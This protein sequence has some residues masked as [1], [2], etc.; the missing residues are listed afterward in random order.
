[1]SET[2]LD[3]LIE[4][5]ELALAFNK[6]A[7]A[8]PI[9]LL[10]PDGNAQ[11]QS[12]IPRIAQRRPV[13]TY[14]SYDPAKL[15][16]PAYWIRCALAGTVEG[17]P[18]GQTPVIYLPGIARSV[19]RTVASVP[20]DIG[21]IAELQFRA[22]WFSH[23]GDHDW[24][25]RSFLSNPAGLGLSVADSKDAGEAMLL[26]LDHLL[27]LPID[28]VS[29]QVLDADFF[30]DLVNP[31]PVRT[32]LGWLDD[33]T[34]YRP[35]L[36]EAQWSAFVQQCR[37]DFGFDPLRDGEIAAAKKLVYR[38]GGWEHVWR[39]FRETPERYPGIPLQL[40][41]AKPMELFVE[42]HEAWPQDN[43]SAEQQL[44]DAL[45]MLP[46]L[47]TEEAR[48]KVAELEAQHAWRRATVWADLDRA[49][50]AF[51]VEQLAL[52]A[53]KSAKPM[54]GTDLD[55]LVAAYADSGWRTDDVVLGAL[56]VSEDP[57]N[58]TA[59]AGAVQVLYRP[60]L[61]AG[62]TTLQKVVGPMANAGT[63]RSDH[64]VDPNPGTVV[65]FVDGLRLDV[66][67]RLRE[68]LVGAGADVELSTVLSALPTVT[69]TAK[70]A[71]VP[72]APGAL[73]TGPDLHP[74]NA[75]TGTR[76]GTPVLRSL[77]ADNN[78]AVL[79][80]AELG[81]PSVGAWTEA[82]DIDRH[83]HA[84]GAA[85]VDSLEEDLGRIARR[86]QELLDA[87]WLRVE[88]VTDHGW[89]LLPGGMEKVDLPVA[90][91]EVKKGRCARL[92]EGSSVE[93]PTVPWHWDPNVRIAVAPG[94]S[95]FE[96]GKEYEHGGVS[97]QECIV[98]RMVVTA[99]VRA[100][101]GTRPEITEVKWLGLLCRIEL[102]GVAEGVHV[103]LRALPADATTS[104]AEE[105]R[106]STRDGR[107]SL[108]VPDEEHE[109][110][111]AYIVLIAPDGAILAQ[112][113]VSVG[114]NR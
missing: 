78:I 113:P 24:T 40:Q 10:W 80:G 47:T 19:M 104:I 76:A 59:V 3:R 53:E 56:A 92:K 83:G 87:G 79:D 57:K 31:D 85:M 93:V 13:L 72:V 11:W 49:P 61:D 34:G 99:G 98:P 51:A 38:E 6:N 63:Y 86:V 17:V 29:R 84:E 37:D 69:Q 96:A 109:G 112:R 15:Q 60:W 110:E 77:M 36:T 14:G 70:A 50:L 58:R 21:P 90:A 108:L 27:D 41:K 28:Q 45:E 9:A 4:R 55:H 68:R 33:P 111:P 48:H 46:K 43:E 8:A 101:A 39:R 66:A 95:C 102:S 73:T 18:T 22:Q 42:P 91:T 35:R 107:V 16:G 44:R 52:L 65:M 62:A 1:V 106:E 32:V 97:P 54:V 81:S 88:I 25:V 5:L 82:G 103:D 74:A 89:M 30:R 64:Q 20:A 67:H 23:P 105:T 94:A 100:R 7:V 71:L 26:A 12:V 114:Q 2:V 75:A